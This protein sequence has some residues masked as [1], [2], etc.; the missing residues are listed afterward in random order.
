[1]KT[2]VF[3]V[4]VCRH[5]HFYTTE[6]RRGGMCQK[7]SVP[8]Q[9]KWKACPLAMPP[10]T[11]SWHDLDEISVL[12]NSFALNCSEVEANQKVSSSP[13]EANI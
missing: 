2:E 12:E 7:L 11:S 8:V 13:T 6:G 10:F 1:M 3:F 5:C 4:S 9:G